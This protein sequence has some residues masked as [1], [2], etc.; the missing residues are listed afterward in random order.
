MHLV[1]HFRLLYCEDAS[2]N[3][4]GCCNGGMHLSHI[5]ILCVGGSIFRF[6]SLAKFWQLAKG[7]GAGLSISD[8]QTGNRE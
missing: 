2:L 3:T 1:I 4:L 8:Y 7:G 5:T 6:G